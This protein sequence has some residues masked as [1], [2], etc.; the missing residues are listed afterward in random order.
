MFISDETV[1]AVRF[2]EPHGHLFA[3]EAAYRAVKGGLY[4]EAVHAVFYRRLHRE[5]RHEA[6]DRPGGRSSLL[7]SRDNGWALLFT[8]T[9]T[10]GVSNKSPM[11]EMGGIEPPSIAVVVRIL[12]AQ[13]VESFCS[14]PTFVTNA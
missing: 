3:T 5:R 11:V 2:N 10:A 1:A 13:S 12:R 14:A 9:S 6:E 4:T 7:N 8:P